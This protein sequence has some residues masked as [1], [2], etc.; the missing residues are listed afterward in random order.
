MK[1]FSA[2]VKKQA[3]RIGLGTIIA[4]SIMAG[5]AIYGLHSYKVERD[6]VDNLK[7]SA[8][9]M[10]AE[11]SSIEKV[12]KYFSDEG[13]RIEKVH[14]KNGELLKKAGDVSAWL[15]SLPGSPTLDE[16]RTDESTKYFNAKQRI[17]KESA[18]SEL[19]WTALTS[20][21]D[22]PKLKAGL[23]KENL[24]IYSSVK[25]C[26]LRGA[27]EG[28]YCGPSAAVGAR[29]VT[30]LGQVDELKQQSEAFARG[31]LA[32]GWDDWDVAQNNLTLAA[33]TEINSE[34][35]KAKAAFDRGDLDQEDWTSMQ[36]GFD[37][38]KT[39][40]ADQI[41][42]DRKELQQATYSGHVSGVNW[43]LLSHWA[44]SAPSTASTHIVNHPYVAGGAAFAPPAPSQGFAPSAAGVKIGAGAQVLPSMPAVSGAA[45]TKVAPGKINYAANIS[46]PKAASPYAINSGASHLGSKVNMSFAKAAGP[47]I[48]MAMSQSGSKGGIGSK[49]SSY[50]TG[51]A[52][53]RSSVGHAGVG[54]SSS[55]HSSG[56]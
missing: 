23:S 36:A 12:R 22:V 11:K 54:H 47:K 44:N 41:A 3:G 1:N 28:A 42:Q 39:T 6:L 46:M 10:Q 35:D 25:D 43:Y 15:G 29:L 2:L 13:G 17:A 31:Q 34:K 38:A 55:G 26:A 30:A 51:R 56:G 5:A 21:Q 14:A 37:A 19:V 50:S 53:A 18:A 45:P 33:F 24:E 9:Q 20:P 7:A 27:G 16:L 8:Q 49:V 40:A 32:M 48:S 4:A 52:A